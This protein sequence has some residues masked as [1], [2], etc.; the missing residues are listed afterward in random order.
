MKSLKHLIDGA[1]K[2]CPSKTAIAHTLGVLPQGLYDYE[3]G[4]RHMPA[5]KVMRLA[6]LANANAVIELGRYEAE[7]L[8]K[9]TQRATAG[10]AGAVSILGVLSLAHGDAKANTVM[11]RSPDAHYAQLRRWIKTVQTHARRLAGLALMNR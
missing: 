5:E 11:P 3:T 10:I 4:R 6:T 8:G 9:K 2:M 7:W 1:L